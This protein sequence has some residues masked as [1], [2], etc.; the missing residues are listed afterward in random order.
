MDQ[1][2][3]FFIIHSNIDRKSVIIDNQ[4]LIIF[5]IFLLFLVLINK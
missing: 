3:E 5:I 2:K 1:P 4:I